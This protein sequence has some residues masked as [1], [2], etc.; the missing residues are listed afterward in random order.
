MP[1]GL[2]NEYWFGE[3]GVYSSL[4]SLTFSDGLTNAVMQ[5]T[6]STYGRS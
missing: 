4:R 3:E 5:F 1:L 2:V 6:V